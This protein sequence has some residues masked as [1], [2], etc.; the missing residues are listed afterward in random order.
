MWGSAYL[1]PSQGRGGG[2]NQTAVPKPTH[3]VENTMPEYEEVNAYFRQRM[4]DSRKIWD[5]RGRE[6]RVAAHQ[7]RLGGSSWRQM[8]GM[9]L[10]MNEIGHIGN[11]PFMVGFA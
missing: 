6:A 5:T 2:T 4:E 8:R 11:R 1:L 10:M 7:A 9:P 3:P